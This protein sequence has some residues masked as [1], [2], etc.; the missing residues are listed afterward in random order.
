MA[1]LELTKEQIYQLA[2]QL[3]AQDKQELVDRLATA[4]NQAPTKRIPGRNKG[5]I[6]AA[7]DCTDL[8]PTDDK[9]PAR[10]AVRTTSDEIMTRV[11]EIY[12]EQLRPSLDTDE[13]LGKFLTIDTLSGDYEV[14]DDSLQNGLRLRE[15]HAEV[16]TGT[17]RIGYAT[18]F[19]RGGRMRPVGK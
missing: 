18:A 6:W 14:S 12:E 9:T 17:L 3:S 8:L 7:P 10:A 15:R 19:A 4:P 16:K 11:K 13:N 5:K 1:V 2:A